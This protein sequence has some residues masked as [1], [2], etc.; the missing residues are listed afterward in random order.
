MNPTAARDGRDLAG[1]ASASDTA[2]NEPHGS[3]GPGAP[4]PDKAEFRRQARVIKAVANEA[5]LM[6][7]YR[8]KDGECSAG[9][10]TE[11]VGLDPSTVSKHLSVLRAAGIVDD[12]RDGSAVYYRLLTPCILAIFTCAAR[13]IRERGH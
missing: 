9:N 10:L 2:S 1:A 12:R 7:V 13:V 6:I 3:G 11:L 4:V 8:L 5:R